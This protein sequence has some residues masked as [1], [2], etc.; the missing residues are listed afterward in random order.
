MNPL[1]CPHQRIARFV[2]VLIGMALVIA[3]LV[4]AALA[5]APLQARAEAVAPGT[6]TVT[7]NI[8]IDRTES[9][10]PINPHITSSA[11]PPKDPVADNATLVVDSDHEGL[12]TVPITVRPMLMKVTGI[13]GLDVMPDTQTEDGRFTKL[14]VNVGTITDTAQIITKPCKVLVEMGTVGGIVSGIKGSHEWNG[15][16]QM[17]FAGLPNSA[18]GEMTPEQ[19]EKLKTLQGTTSAD[20]ATQ[21]ALTALESGSGQPAAASDGTSTGAPKQPGRTVMHIL[22]RVLLV[23]LIPLVIAAASL[24]IRVKR[25]NRRREQQAALSNREDDANNERR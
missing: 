10:L 8:W 16:F 15:T 21:S 25:R 13:S 12:L 4:I 1:S 5:M 23:V 18:A 6:Y 11:F 2:S 14:V 3:A 24:I 9:G 7:C 19:A 20:S 17:Q 22:D